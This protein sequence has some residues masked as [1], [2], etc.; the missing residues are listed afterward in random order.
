MFAKQC[1]DNL[2]CAIFNISVILAIVGKDVKYLFG[3]F[4]QKLRNGMVFVQSEVTYSSFY[5]HWVSKH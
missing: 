3:S 2:V 4:H 1:C 5:E